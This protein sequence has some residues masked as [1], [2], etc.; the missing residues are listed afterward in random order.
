MTDTSLVGRSLVIF[1]GAL[2]IPIG[3]MN[4]VYSLGSYATKIDAAIAYN[5][6]SVE[7]HGPFA[8]LNDMDKFCG[9]R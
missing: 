2:G 9:G 8:R 1:L 7:F 6:G 5:F 4:R 3:I